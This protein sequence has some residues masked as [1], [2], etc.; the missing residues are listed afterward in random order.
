MRVYKGGRCAPRALSL[1]TI[2][3]S[4]TLVSWSERVACF[5]V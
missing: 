3:F 4:G 2:G 1:I 5:L